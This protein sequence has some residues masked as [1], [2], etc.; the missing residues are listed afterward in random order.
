MICGPFA[1]MI[2]PVVVF[3]FIV[4]L[5]VIISLRLLNFG[6]SDVLFLANRYACRA[7]TLR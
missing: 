7:I 1:N 2:R 3:V 6:G 5:G 4:I